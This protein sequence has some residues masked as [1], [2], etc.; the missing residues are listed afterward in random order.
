MNAKTLLPLPLPLPLSLPMPLLFTIFTCLIL[1]PAQLTAQTLSSTDN[2]NFQITNNGATLTCDDANNLETALVT[3]SDNSTQTFTKRNRSQIIDLLRSD[4]NNP[5]MAKTC[6]SGITDMSSII[7]SKKTFNQDIGSW[8]V[9]KVTDMIFMFANINDF[10]QD[11]GEWDVSQV[12]NMSNMFRFNRAFNKDIGSWDV[13]AV[14]NMRGMFSSSRAFNQ[15][16]GDWDVSSVTDMRS[17][18]VNPVFNQDIGKWDVSQVTNMSQMFRGNGAFNQDIGD[19]DVSNVT[20]M[21]FMF[22]SARAFNKDIGSWDVSQVTDIRGMFASNPNNPHTFNQDIGGWDVSQTTNIRS[23]FFGNT[24]FNQDIGDWDVS[25]VKR[26]GFMFKEADAF[27]QDIGD[28]DV[29]QVNEMRSMF[30]E[31]DAFGQDLSI[32]CVEQITSVP[33]D[34]D[35][36]SGFEGQTGKQPQWGTCPPLSVKALLKPANEAT[37]VGVTPEFKWQQADSAATYDLRWADNENFSDSTFVE[38]LTDTTHTPGTALEKGVAYYWQV[39]GVE[40]TATSEWSES[41]F[42]TTIPKPSTRNPNIFRAE[43]GVTIICTD[44]EVGEIGTVDGIGYT[45]RSKDQI[46]PVNA[47]TTCTSGIT[48]M[49]GL[50]Q[51]EGSFNED[52]SH[53]DVSSVTDMSEM[54]QGGGAF[55]TADSHS[56]NQD[57]GSWDVSQVNNMSGMF[58][59][60]NKFNQ[61][62]GSWN[63]GQVTNM[64]RMFQGAEAFNQDIGKWDVSQVTN[65][66]GMFEGGFLTLTSFNK[67]IGSW[68]VSQVINMSFMFANVDAFNQDIGGW[69]VSQ[70]TNMR[71]MFSNAD[72]LAQ[73]IGSWDVSQVT[74]MRLMFRNAAAFNQDI[75][76]WDVS[77]VT[78][79]SF[80]FRS[81]SAFNQDIGNWDVSQVTDM[82]AMFLDATDFNQDIGDWD[83]SQVTN[84]RNMFSKTSVFNQN[85]GSWDVS[86]VTVMS[87]MFFDAAA[88]NQDIGS[89][90]VSQVTVMAGMFS[91]ATAF[92][93][94]IGGWD[95]SQVTNMRGMFSGDFS[96]TRFNQDISGWDVGKVKKI[97][98]M[99]F[100]ADSFNQDIG[101]W[102]VSQVIDMKNMFKNAISFDQDIGGWDVSNVNDT[103]DLDDSFEGFLAGV[104]LSPENYDALLIGWEQLDLTK[105]LTFDAGRSRFTTDAESARQDIINDDNW[106][107]NDGGLLGQQQNNTI[108]L[109]ENW[110]LVGLPANTAE[111]GFQTL[112]PKAIDGTLFEFTGGSYQQ[113][114][115]LALATGY[116]VRLAAPDTVS[117]EGAPLDSLAIALESGWN[118]IAGGSSASALVN[119]SD[120]DG[121]LIPGTLFE[122][123]GAYIPSDTLKPG[124]GY[125]VRTSDAGSVTVTPGSPNSNAALAKSRVTEDTVQLSAT[126]RLKAAR[127]GMNRLII[128]TPDGLSQ[129]LYL[130]ELPDKVDPRSFSLPPAPLG[131]R[132]DA[133]FE[134]DRGQSSE[135]KS[136]IQL[137]SSGDFRPQVRYERGEAVSVTSRITLNVQ[138]VEGNA[139]AESYTLE[140]GQSRELAAAEQIRIEITIESDVITS[141]D[142]DQVDVPNELELQQNFPNPFNPSTTI[143]YALPEQAQVNLTVYDMLGQRVAILLSGQVQTAGTHSV[144][145]DASNLS[146]GMYIYRLQT[147]SQSITRKMI[148]LK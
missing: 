41:F 50:F 71:G 88:F 67:D 6:T 30:E 148:L 114:S 34:F 32:W 144:N 64:E 96:F 17:M 70:V 77:K 113:T 36:N 24:A 107:I 33:R 98:F 27:N 132:L 46:T 26:M 122:F 78:D 131:A 42:F 20:D 95:V 103:T 14:T 44:A 89:W 85:I 66:A 147:G 99:F 48:D 18:F 57:I 4:E 126:D 104:E 129:T 100:G 143:Q 8:D 2:T 87:D 109:A 138:L 3:F 82:S 40:E 43:N 83:V 106:T 37:E 10:N 76:D 91:N 139:N 81:D 79:M 28:W 23:M 93:Q 111:R 65:M 116:W 62:I 105:G 92:N 60:A 72:A 118:M 38:G 145:F 11:I 68:D 54:F 53:W 15:D 135:T 136:T 141:V 80:M 125:W 69:D 127:A 9:S 134:G 90:D 97:D 31:A 45:K 102:D 110:N 115:E 94:D 73:N 123:A 19:W 29:S 75:G 101:G 120:P 140:P 47:A 39:R 1:M 74:D 124:S 142:D 59:N 86:G 5:E 128:S 35:L 58:S 56:F 61:N 108:T 13:S 49:S 119:L 21:S 25:Q 137:N 51:N 55:D 22:E 63:V 52:I 12:T 121:L 7:R 146:S 16:I 84:M 133:R 112:F 130:G 117:L